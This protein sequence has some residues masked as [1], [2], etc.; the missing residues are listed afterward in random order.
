[1]MIFKKGLFLLS[2]IALLGISLALITS[3]EWHH[4]PDNAKLL[5]GMWINTKVDD[6]DILTDDAFIM[7]FKSD[8]T[9]MYA[10]G[11]QENENNK[12][13]RENTSYTYSIV[14]DTISIDGSAMENVFHMKF[15]I[16]SIDKATIHYSVP[17][18]ALNGDIIPDE[19]TYIC[20]KI[21]HDLSDEFTGI[22]YGRC[23]NE[24]NTDSLYHYWEYL[25]DSSYYYYYQDESGNWIKK[26]DNE[27]RYYLYGQFLATNYSHDLISGGTGK[28]FECWNFT[29]DGDSMTWTG[30]RENNATITYQM[31]KVSSAPDIAQ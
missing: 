22:W 3:C 28:A 20:K 13:W 30:L 5:N 15:E 31:E 9:E 16:L 7:D 8:N 23:T 24:G 14:G 17:A 29:I 2:K 4:N 18:F 25:S 19:K 27:G 26:I 10:I 6:Q 21:T 11:L 12:S 1:M